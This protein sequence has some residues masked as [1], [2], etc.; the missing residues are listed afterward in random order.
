MKGDTE[1]GGSSEDDPPS[2]MNP[3]AQTFVPKED[4]NAKH[5]WT[6]MSHGIYEQQRMDDTTNAANCKEDE[7]TVII[8]SINITN[9]DYNDAAVTSRNAAV[10]FLQ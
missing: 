5:V 4:S 9:L 7:D 2:I 10:V 1:E 3:E 8:E 6:A